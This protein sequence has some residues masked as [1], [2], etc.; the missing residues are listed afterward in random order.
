MEISPELQN[1]EHILND[2]HQLLCGLADLHDELALEGKDDQISERIRAKLR[3]KME[4]SGAELIQCPK[5]DSSQQRAV[6]V[7][8]QSLSE[9]RLIR[10]LRTGVAYRG[11]IIRKEEVEISK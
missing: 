10:S 11:K 6:K 8:E 4:L 2:L 3:D 9:I 1:H 5:W 7:Q